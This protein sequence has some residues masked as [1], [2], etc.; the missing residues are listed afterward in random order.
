MKNGEIF[1]VPVGSARYGQRLD[2]S[3]I[4]VFVLSE[5]PNFRPENEAGVSWFV[6]SIADVYRHW[7]HPV[8]FEDLTGDCTGNKQVCAFLRKYRG[9]ITYAAP[10]QAVRF[11]LE[12]IAD[13]ERYQYTSPIKAGLRTAMIL[14]HMAE[15]REDPFLLDEDEK[16]ILIRARTGGVPPEERAEIYRRTICPENLDKLRRM[17]ENTTIKAEL[18]ALLDEIKEERT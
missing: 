5:D 2:S 14:A 4:D 3:D 12:Y 7:G 1:R 17:P 10:I 15:R 13:G 8:L 18:F 16:A 11:G 9:D 6:W